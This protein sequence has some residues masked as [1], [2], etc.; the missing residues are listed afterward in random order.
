[1]VFATSLDFPRFQ[2]TYVA[3]LEYPRFLDFPRFLSTYVA[4][5][6]FP[7][8]SEIPAIS[9]DHRRLAGIS[10]SFWIS[11]AFCRLTSRRWISRAFVDC[12]AISV[13]ALSSISE[14][15]PRSPASSIS[16]AFTLELHYY[17]VIR[18]ELS[19]FWIARVSTAYTNLSGLN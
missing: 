14:I 5:L 17:R 12:R 7:A 15:K 1:M 11:R 8:L 10:R 13:P 9:V 3:S 18:L 19:L 2:S 16:R 6:E 4:S